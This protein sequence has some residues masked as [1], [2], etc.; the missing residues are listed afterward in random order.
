MLNIVLRTV[1]IPQEG[2]RLGGAGEMAPCLM[3]TH[4]WR[5]SVEK[6]GIILV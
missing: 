4:A 5:L 1:L 2:L 3:V 6:E